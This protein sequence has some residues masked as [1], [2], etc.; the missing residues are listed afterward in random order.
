MSHE[1]A[2]LTIRD[3]TSGTTIKV[4]INTQHNTIPASAFTAL[5]ISQTTPLPLEPQLTPL[6]IFDPGFKNTVVCKSRI[7]QLDENGGGLRYRGYSVEELVEKSSFLEVAF[8]LINGELPTKAEN[9]KWTQ[10]ILSHTYLHT[11][12]EKQM[13][14]FRYDAH[15]M[16]MLISTVASLSTMYMKPKGASAAQIAKAAANRNR[17]VLRILGKIPTIASF[18]Y[19]NRIGRE[20]NAPMPRCKNYAEN[21]LYMIDKLNEPDYVPDA[22]IVSILDKMFILLAEHG[23]NCSSI[24]MRHLASSGVD[25]YTALSGS[26][27]ALFGERKASAVMIMLNQIGTPEN[28]PTFLTLVK[29]KSSVIKTPAGTLAASPTGRPTRLQGFGHRIYKSTKSLA[30]QLFSI[31]GQT[32][33]MA[34]LAL[35]LESQVLADKWFQDRHLFPNIDFWTA[36]VFHT[37]GFPPDMFPVLT[38]VPRAAGLIAHWAESL[39]DPEYK[40][41]RPRQIFWGE[42][43]KDYEADRA[44]LAAADEVEE[45]VQGG[46]GYVKSLPAQANKRLSLNATHGIDEAKLLEF[47]AMIERTKTSIQEL[48]ALNAGAVQVPSPTSPSATRRK[49]SIYQPITKL[50]AWVMGQPTAADAATSEKLAKTQKELQDLL[51]QQQELLELYMTHRAQVQQPVGGSGSHTTSS[52][53]P[54]KTVSKSSSV[55]QLNKL[56]IPVPDLLAGSHSPRPIMKKLNEP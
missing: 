2:F 47:K 5:K 38:A 18:A 51:Q 12:L 14:T 11:E 33:E 1:E 30:L 35:E 36:V 43:L 15:P 23:N 39:D 20:F 16:G 26:F 27:G 3:P 17:A 55:D 4:P 56:N 45:E 46:D 53:S 13:T 50:G 34:T 49:G 52:I 7:S 44:A 31:L 10:G 9:E 8:L 42:F 21:F 54:E 22:R 6:R 25:P 32:N 37:L 24:T 41:Y 40:I 48:S 28:I 29:Q 19:R